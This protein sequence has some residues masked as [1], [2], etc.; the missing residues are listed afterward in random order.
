MSFDENPPSPDKI[1]QPH[2]ATTKVNFA[3]AGG[4]LLFLL[5]VHSRSG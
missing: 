3:V 1:I 4:V 5:S 2:K